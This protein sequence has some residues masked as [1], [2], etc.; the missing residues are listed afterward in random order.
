MKFFPLAIL[1]Q[2]CLSLAGPLE[3]I[4]W[5]EGQW[6][7]NF[8]KGT[9]IELIYSKPKDGQMVAFMKTFQ[10]DGTLRFLEFFEMK[11]EAGQIKM[12]SY[13]PLRSKKTGKI[14]IENVYFESIKIEPNE[15][16]FKRTGGS[17]RAPTSFTIFRKSENEIQEKVHFNKFTLESSLTRQ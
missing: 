8:T 6:K 10:D 1:I 2:S 12:K 9:P 15:I 13:L 5:L 16:S 4:S 11:E 7:G 17:K 14:A 3:Q